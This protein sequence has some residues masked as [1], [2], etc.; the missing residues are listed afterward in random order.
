MIKEKKDLHLGLDGIPRT[1]FTIE[2][3]GEARFPSPFAYSTVQGDSI[4]N[5]VED[6]EHVLFDARYDSAYTPEQ[7]GN[8]AAQ[9]NLMERAGPRGK[10][11]FDP[12]RV[13]AG[14]CTCGGLCPGLNDVIRAIVRSLTIGYKIKQ[15]WGFRYGFKGMLKDS[16]FSPIVLTKELV[17]DIHKQGGSFL[18][19]ARGGTEK[20]NDI[21]DTLMKH[22]INVLFVIGGDGSQK[23][24]KLIAETAEK[25]GY[26]LSVV[27]VP[28]TI[29]NDLMFIQK[30]FGF[31]TAVAKA[32]EAVSAAHI[33]AKGAYN[34]IGLVKVMGRDSGFIAA[35]TALASHEVNFVLIPE[36]PF[37][38]YG[39][40][41]LLH[42]LQQRLR[43]KNHAVI[44]V[45]EGA[46]QNLMDTE[47]GLLNSKDAGGNKKMHDIGPYLR[48]KIMQ[49]FNE[50]G[51]DI[52]VRYI[53]PSYIIRAS[54][55]VPSDALYCARLGANAVHAAMSGRTKV[56]MSYWSGAYVHVPIT[57]ATQK[58]NKLN[59]ESSLWR[60]VLESTL[61]PPVMNN[62]S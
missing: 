40:N 3:L 55:P 1:D 32:Q 43:A 2:K 17:D 12:Q 19:S 35:E 51:M 38:L 56:L 48:E 28:K 62:R 6:S 57:L 21:V 26:Q 58:R 10:L 52:S 25:R 50:I 45:A 42:L 36:V 37:D 53:D 13:T 31:E 29:D 4:V 41:G 7:N 59:P 61:Q 44:V 15:V 24:A 27:G 34:G 30:T 14:I 23:G 49:Y 33:E 16:P 11:Y 46:G 54:T 20:P 8:F 18:G 39:A 5:F 47:V 22:H 60:D 9:D